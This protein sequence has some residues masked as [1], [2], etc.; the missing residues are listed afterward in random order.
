MKIYVAC[1]AA[2]NNGFLHGAWID[3]EGK[4]AIEIEAEVHEMLKRSPEPDAEEWAIHDFEG[5]GDYKV[6]EWTSFNEIA[7][8]VEAV[9][10]SSYKLDLIT[11][12]MS[13]MCCSAPDAISYI[14]DNFH[15]EFDNL[16]AYAW[17]WLESSGDWDLIPKHLQ[18]YFDIESYARDLDLNGDIISIDSS[19]GV[20][21]LA[22]T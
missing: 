5:F 3:C 19:K 1:L 12:V 14:E 21:I 7:E 8:L 13:H 16:K 11:G 18:Y 20:Y 4:D 17:D 22:N 9:N 15:G 2:Y 10:D 6:E